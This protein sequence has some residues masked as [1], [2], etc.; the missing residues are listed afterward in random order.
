MA[1]PM[2]V[3]QRLQRVLDD[4]GCTLSEAAQAAGMPRQQVWKILSGTVPNPGIL[5]VEKIVRA[6]GGTMLE[7]F[8][9]RD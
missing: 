3:A 7:F 8:E 1:G 9:D 4:R 5:T 2:T 6:A